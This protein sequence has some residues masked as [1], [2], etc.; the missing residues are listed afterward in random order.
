MTASLALGYFYLKSLHFFIPFGQVR[1]SKVITQLMQ[2]VGSIFH[3]APV[4]SNQKWDMGVFI[5]NTIL[6]WC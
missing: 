1:L 5:D 6:G 3:T 2:V 4:P